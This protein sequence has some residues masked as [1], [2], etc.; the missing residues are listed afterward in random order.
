MKGGPAVRDRDWQPLGRMGACS[1]RLQALKTPVLAAAPCF[2]GGLVYGDHFKERSPSFA[3]STGLGRKLFRPA[4]Q[5]FPDAGLQANAGAWNRPPGQSRM[6]K[7]AGPGG[8]A[9]VIVADMAGNHDNA[10]ALICAAEGTREA[11]LSFFRFCLW[12]AD[13]AVAPE[14]QISL[15]FNI[16]PR[17]ESFQPLGDVVPGNLSPALRSASSVF[18]RTMAVFCHRSITIC[19]M[20]RSMLPSAANG[21]QPICTWRSRPARPRCPSAR[22]RR[23]WGCRDRTWPAPSCR[24]RSSWR[25]SAPALPRRS[26]P[27]PTCRG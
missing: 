15:A 10:V 2:R 17:I 5:F 11:G 24:S 19:L 9:F 7:K 12:E 14:G 23:R 26:R 16:A 13:L 8:P 18:A 20:A 27:R 25:R 3:L 6:A 1:S 21:P 4:V 22:R